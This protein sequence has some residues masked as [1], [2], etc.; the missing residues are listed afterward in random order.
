M[1]CMLCTVN[2]YVSE[3]SWAVHVCNVWCLNSVHGSVCTH[4]YMLDCAYFESVVLNFCCGCASLVL[5]EVIFL[6]TLM[7]ND[8]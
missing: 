5:L 7:N 4:N 1:P 6:E 2:T 8:L 3:M